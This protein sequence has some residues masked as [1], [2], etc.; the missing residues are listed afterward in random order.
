MNHLIGIETFPVEAAKEILDKAREYKANRGSHEKPLVGQTWNLIFAKSST[1]TRVSFEVGIHELGGNSVFLAAS[2][3]QLG[4]GEPIQDT[5]RVMGRM[6]HGAVMRTYDQKDVEIFAQYSGIPT[7]NALTDQE[8][9]CQ[10]LADIFTYEE[11]R[12]PIQGKRVAFIGDADCNMGRSFAYAAEKFDFQVVF[13]APD[14]YQCPVDNAH[15]QR[16]S[17]PFDAAKGADVLYTDV[18]VSMG[19]EEEA[20]HRLKA[21]EGYQINAEMVKAANSG[22]LV[23]HCLPAYRGKE[24]TEEVLEANAQDI[25]DQAENRLHVQKGI[26]RWLDRTR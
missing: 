3:I 7:I 20:S 21:F 18:W 5:A 13:S 14:Q 1:R 24:I 19:K 25:F 4:R 16:T 11:K 23:Q 8:H 22:V 26:I 6:N 15:V 10:V 12:G 2:E 17:D 9:P